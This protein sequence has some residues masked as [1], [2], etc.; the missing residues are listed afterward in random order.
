MKINLLDWI[1][2]F[3][4]KS[5]QIEQNYQGEEGE[6]FLS[7]VRDGFHHFGNEWA[8][9]NA[10]LICENAIAEEAKRYY[11]DY[12]VSEIRLQGFCGG[13]GANL[14]KMQKQWRQNNATV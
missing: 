4:E 6:N 7:G 10:I 13:Y 5:E 1:N 12:P 3:L 14:L 8:R 9:S 2:Q 11:K